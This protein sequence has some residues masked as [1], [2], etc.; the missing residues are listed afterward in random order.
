MTAFICTTSGQAVT[1]ADK[2]GIR[3]MFLFVAR[4]KALDNTLVVS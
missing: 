3:P 2:I 4:R 1:L